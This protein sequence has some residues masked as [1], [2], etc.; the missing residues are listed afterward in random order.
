M[1]CILHI[2][3][4]K[5]WGCFSTPQSMHVIGI[6]AYL[7]HT[8]IEVNFFCK[9][10]W[11]C[12]FSDVQVFNPLAHIHLAT[13]LSFCPL[14]TEDTNKK[15]KWIWSVGQRSWTRPL[16]FSIPAWWYGSHYQSCLQ[17]IGL[18]VC[19]QAQAALYCLY[20]Y[21]AGSVFLLSSIVCIRASHFSVNHPANSTL[22]FL[23][24]NPYFAIA[25]WFLSK[26]IYIWIH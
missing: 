5:I 7:G 20:S 3:V 22:N 13:S 4:P 12:A 9:W 18:S 23:V 19:D 11:H 1:C 24:I 26:L 10:L 17:E 16:V 25:G 14:V 8:I 2:E 15:R 6:C 21:A